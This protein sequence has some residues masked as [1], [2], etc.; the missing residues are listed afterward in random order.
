MSTAPTLKEERFFSLPKAQFAKIL[1]DD[2]VHANNTLETVKLKAVSS[3][4]AVTNY[5]TAF[6]LTKK[7]LTNDIKQSDELKFTFPYRGIHV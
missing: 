4:G 2:Y 7:G 6:N 5:K 3:S 1:S